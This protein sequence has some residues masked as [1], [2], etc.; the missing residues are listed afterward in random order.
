MRTKKTKAQ[1]GDIIY[2]W[3]HDGTTYSKVVAYTVTP[4]T[5]QYCNE[6]LSKKSPT[7][8]INFTDA[9]TALMKYLRN[10]ASVYHT[11]INTLM[12]T[13]KSEVEELTF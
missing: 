4:Q 8:W 7:M 2:F 12:T 6:E 13:T 3:K 5:L 1:V 10:Q 9:R 11:S